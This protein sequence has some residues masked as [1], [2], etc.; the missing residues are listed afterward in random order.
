[1]MHSD[2]MTD[3]SQFLLPSHFVILGS[4]TVFAARTESCLRDKCR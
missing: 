1:M 4:L 3:L 2:H